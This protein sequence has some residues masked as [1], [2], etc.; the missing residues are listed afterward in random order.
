MAKNKSLDKRIEEHKIS[1][2]VFHKKLG[3]KG[4]YLDSGLSSKRNPEQTRMRFNDTDEY[5]VKTRS[6]GRY[7]VKP[8]M[9]VEEEHIK[10]YTFLAGLVKQEFG[11]L[12]NITDIKKED[13]HY[14]ITAEVSHKN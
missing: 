7:F 3:I 13:N 1:V 10:T 2:D 11:I 5:F 8:A 6:P 14:K 9:K 4:T 12:G